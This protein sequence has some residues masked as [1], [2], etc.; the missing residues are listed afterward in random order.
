MKIVLATR[1]MGKI[2]EI[3][4]ILTNLD[5]EILTL[6]EFPEI[7][8]P[9][10]DGKDFEENALKKAKFVANYLNMPAL[11]DDSGI[12]VEAL[13]KRPGILSARYAGED[14]TDEENNGKLL[15]ELE[16][17]PF[18]K[19]RASYRCVIALVL[20]SGREEII[21]GSCYGFIALEP[22]GSEGFGYD[23]LFYVP[24]YGKTM[25]ELPLE[26]KNRI[27]HRGR[28]MA[29]LKEKLVE[30]LSR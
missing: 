26:I 28:A 30:I 17:I 2:K 18:E 29:K 16:G 5:L 27:S 19:R 7:P 12:E 22:K 14:A 10:E 9:V 21:E 8:P 15:K 24:E 4:D 1:N 3:K 20:P 25:A 6:N 13:N 11:A 23:P